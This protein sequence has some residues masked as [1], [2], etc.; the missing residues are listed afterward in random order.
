VKRDGGMSLLEV[1][2]VIAIIVILATVSLSGLTGIVGYERLKGFAMDMV[3]AMNNARF[4][5]RKEGERVCL[6]IS[7]GEPQ[8]WIDKKMLYFSFIDANKNSKYD[9]GE[10]K[11]AE[12]YFR[13]IKVVENDIGKTCVNFENAKCL[14]FFPVGT[15]LIGNSDRK[16]KLKLKNSCYCIKVYRN[17]GLMDAYACDC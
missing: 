17:V 8:N 4:V 9:T 10:K 14:Y 5:A 12:G 7:T 13:G 16:I 11:L 15:P 1:M 6:V 3:A 2:V